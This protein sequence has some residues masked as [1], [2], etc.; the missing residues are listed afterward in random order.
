MIGRNIAYKGFFP[1]LQLPSS[2]IPLPHHHNNPFHLPHTGNTCAYHNI[3]TSPVRHTYYALYFGWR[4]S[5][6]TV[7]LTSQQNLHYFHSPPSSWLVPQR[8]VLPSS[9]N[10][11]NSVRLT[12]DLLPPVPPRTPASRPRPRCRRSRP[13]LVF[14]T[15]DTMALAT[16]LLA[17]APAH[18]LHAHSRPLL[19]RLRCRPVRLHP[20]RL[21]APLR[22]C[23]LPLPLLRVSLAPWRRSTRTSTWVCKAGT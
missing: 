8:S 20:V 16:Y 11:N 3:T 12:T 21:R 23:H 7:L 1:F 13:S 6:K 10:N 4:H 22:P 17:L 2:Y 5:R 18:P 9:S 15:T 14:S 19:T